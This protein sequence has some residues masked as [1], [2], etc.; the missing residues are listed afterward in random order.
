[1]QNK[2]RIWGWYLF[3]WACQP[4]NTLMLTFI[5]GPFFAT[6]AVQH[7][8][9]SGLGEDA[10]DAKAQTLWSNALTL[11]GLLIGIAAPVLGAIAD[12]A[13]RRM[14][15]IGFFTLLLIG[16]GALTW[17]SDPNG[18]NLIF[19]LVA[20][21]IGFI[22]AELAYIFANA[23]LPELGQGDEIGELSGSGFATGYIGGVISLVIV[24]TLFVAQ[25]NGKTLIGLDPLFG[26]DPT[27][28][29]GTRFVGP[30]VALW[31]AVFAIPY[32]LW[33]NERG[34]ERTRA[35]FSIAMSRLKSSIADLRHRKS[36]A[37]FLIASMFYRDALNGLYTFGGIY[38]T[39]VLNWTVVKIGTFGIIAAISAALFSW[40]G[41]KLDRRIGPKPVVA[42]AIA[43]LIVVCVIIVNL[44]PTTLF[45]VVL[46]DG[47][48]LPD[49]IF[50]ICG[51]LIGGLGGVLQSSSRTFMVRHTRKG[52][53]TMEFGLYGLSGRATAFLAPLLISIATTVTGSARLGVSPLIVLF[54]IGL[55]LLSFVHPK[56][57]AGEWS[58]T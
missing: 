44:T 21:C 15:W 25:G 35:S 34:L 53:E 39:L 11:V 12:S 2:K 28:K 27:Q 37:N 30:F 51:S 46:A 36:Q 19:M 18:S 41:G 3:D 14:P 8:L 23:Q 49:T 22:G 50:Y 45:G 47:S 38:A 24:L 16:G 31:A 56:G 32:F 57:D 17:Y 40:L 6:V 5:F 1:M 55:I 7:F 54:I 13:G 10:A 33:M 58:D 26:F 9:A 20:F 43:I 42:G 29:E 4:Y 52:R 48:S